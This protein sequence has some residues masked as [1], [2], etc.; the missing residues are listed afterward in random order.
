ME[1]I[2]R[3]ANLETHEIHILKKLATEALLASDL[4]SALSIPRA[5]L[6]RMLKRLL[7]RGFVT[8]I[9]RGKRYVY[10]ATPRDVLL[11]KYGLTDKHTAQGVRVYQGKTAMLELTQRFIHLHAK[12]RVKV[13][14]TKQ[15]WDFWSKHLTDE[16]NA[17]IN[18]L[19][20][21]KEVINEG[22]FSEALLTKRQEVFLETYQTRPSTVHIWP[23]KYAQFT[24]DI[25]V[26]EK[27]L[28]I[29]NWRDE[30]GI[31]ITC[32]DTVSAFNQIFSFISDNTAVSSIY[33]KGS[34]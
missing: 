11:S 21:R 25:T 20:R 30:V 33:A 26:T 19:L 24:T 1:P 12:R 4:S 5:S 13:L 2:F 3:L 14:Q 34:A 6:D 18:T 27:E 22:I 10:K 28:Y 16:Q 8:K 17:T 15:T 32:I 9:K 7:D 29:M 23:E 31:E